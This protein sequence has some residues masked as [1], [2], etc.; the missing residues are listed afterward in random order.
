MAM[1]FL[2]KADWMPFLLTRLKTQTPPGEPINNVTPINDCDGDGVL[3][4]ADAFPL[5]PTNDSDDDGVANN[6]DVY[7]EN[8]LYSKDSDNDGMPDAWETKYGLDPND[9]S[10]VSSD[11]DNDGV[12]ALDEFLAGTIPS[13]SLDIDGNEKYD[14]LTDGLLLLRERHVWL[15]GRRSCFWNCGVGCHIYLFCGYCVPH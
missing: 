14:A 5:D 11:Q 7:P 4:P 12:A 13:G 8:S 3:D 1:A 9:A 15:D 6:A 10:D 2:A